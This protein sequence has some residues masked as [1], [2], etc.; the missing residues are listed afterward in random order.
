MIRTVLSLFD[1]MSCGQ[2][3]LRENGQ[4]FERYYASEIDKK[5]IEQTKLNFPDTIQLGDITR[6]REWDIDWSQVDL[7]LAGSP[8]QGFSSAGLGL[9]FSD[10]R[11]KLYFVFEDIL[12]FAQTQNPDVKFLLEN[13]RMSLENMSVIT[14]RLRLYPV[15]I[16]A[17]RVSAQHWERFYWTNLRTKRDETLNIDVVDIPQPADRNIVLRDI[18]EENVPEDYFLSDNKVLHLTNGSN[19]ISGLTVSSTGLRPFKNDGRNGS[20]SEYGTMAFD[21]QKCGTL[22]T[23]NTPKVVI[24]VGNLVNGAGFK[25]P[26][27]G[28]VYAIEG[29]CPTLTAGSGGALEP[30]LLIVIDDKTYRIRRMTP[31]EMSKAQSIPEWYVWACAKTQVQKMTGNG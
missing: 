21:T 3:A 23:T 13:V 12:K 16:D 24:Q 1:G 14:R 22:T 25:N 11:S 10:P 6:W 19:R 30:K 2:I 20:L 31:G 15:N 17:A 18:L 29:K 27:R 5:A 8:C 9:N 4:T 28:R 7:I 26:Q